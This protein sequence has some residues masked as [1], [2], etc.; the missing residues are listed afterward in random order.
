MTSVFPTTVARCKAVWSPCR[1]MWMQEQQSA[2]PTPPCNTQTPLLWHKDIS[3]PQLEQTGH[4]ARQSFFVHKLSGNLEPTIEQLQCWPR[5]KGQALPRRPKEWQ[6]LGGL[7]L[8]HLWKV[9]E[10]DCVCYAIKPAIFT[11]Y[12]VL[13]LSA[14]FQRNPYPAM[15]A[16]NTHDLMMGAYLW[17]DLYRLRVTSRFMLCHLRT[18]GTISYHCVCLWSLFWYFMTASSLI[19]AAIWPLSLW[20]DAGDC[21]PPLSSSGHQR[22][23]DSFP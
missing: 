13:P 4:H 19:Y 3:S 9:W 5:N 11:P 10:L 21:W 8:S 22:E 18:P 16:S 6:C 12:W 15:S 14:F 1:V 2:L 17:T 7:W 20:S 23:L